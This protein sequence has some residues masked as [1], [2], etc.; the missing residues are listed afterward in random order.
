MG[1]SQESPDL[2]EIV[3]PKAEIRRHIPLLPLLSLPTGGQG[4]VLGLPKSPASLSTL[5]PNVIAQQGIR[6]RVL[7]VVHGGAWIGAWASL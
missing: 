3:Q 7:Q 6:V 2:G 1:L 5:C 4:P